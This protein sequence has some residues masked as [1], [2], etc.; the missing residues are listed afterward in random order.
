[1][2]VDYADPVQLSSI[3]VDGDSAA[4]LLSHLIGD[5]RAVEALET[6]DDT[7]PRR[8][9]GES[10]SM[11]Q[12]SDPR[13]G[14]NRAR[15]AFR[16]GDA[17]IMGR[18]A[19]LE[20][21]STDE[22][23]PPL[24]RATAALEAAYEAEERPE[25]TPSVVAGRRA[26]ITEAAELLDQVQADIAWV[27]NGKPKLA[28]RLASL[29]FGALNDA[30]GLR[31]VADTLTGGRTRSADR[32][33]APAAARA[34]SMAFW[35]PAVRAATLTDGG[36]LRVRTVGPTDDLWM[37]VTARGSQVL[38]ALVPVLKADRGGTAE[39]VVP[40]DLRLDD[41]ELTL[42][43]DPL[44]LPAS[45][46][47]RAMRAV[48]L[49]QKAVLLR[50]SDPAAA[51]ELWEDCAAMWEDLGDPT[52]AAQARQYAEHGIPQR[53]ATLAEEIARALRRR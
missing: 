38:I 17:Q 9:V 32:I 53:P 30:P 47:D 49:G 2:Y 3:A 48:R 24:V 25:L 8:L 39:A 34:M 31:E 33:A 42:T 15:D 40:H 18:L 6:D 20:A 7:R 51:R 36:L 14:T 37:R 29:C 52:R 13:F 26:R 46:L 10:P 50:S 22:D 1:M 27:A 11:G 19:F 41:L 16:P 5:D 35:E 44:P 43:V 12:Q 4:G 21:L 28:S 23:L 45:S